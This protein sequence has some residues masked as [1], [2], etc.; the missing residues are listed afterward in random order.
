MKEF[1]EASNNRNKRKFVCG[2]GVNDAPYKICNNGL[3]CPYYKVWLA[4][5]NRCYNNKR[6]IYFDCFVCREWRHFMCFR[7]WMETQDWVNMHLDKDI[8]IRK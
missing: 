5:I 4:M 7:E 6:K 1:V 3:T 2:V 8:N